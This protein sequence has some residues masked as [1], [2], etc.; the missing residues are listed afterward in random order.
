MFVH[1]ILY[2]DHYPTLFYGDSVHMRTPIALN[3]DLAPVVLWSP[4]P[5]RAITSK[6]S[7]HN[8]HKRTKHRA[9]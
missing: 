1:L 9:P 6:E 2:S 7:I 3:E 4:H 8:G 5:A